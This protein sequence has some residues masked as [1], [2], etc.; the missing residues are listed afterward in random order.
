MRLFNYFIVV[1]LLYIGIGLNQ[2]S[3][4]TDIIQDEFI[5]RVHPVGQGNCVTV[6]F[7]DKENGSPEY[8]IVDLGTSSI[9]NESLIGDVLEKEAKAAPGGG[10]SKKKKSENK[11]KKSMESESD[12]LDIIKGHK[13][14]KLP[15]KEF[16]EECLEGI[17]K[18]LSLNQPRR[19]YIK[20]VVLTHGDVDH[21]NE[22]VN[23]VRKHK[24]QI[25]NLILGGCGAQINF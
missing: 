8:M 11:T 23:F 4:G 5:V 10:K 9:K 19:K 20:V 1:L 13:H 6:K 18:L 15:V 3:I 24:Y 12:L 22:L 2:K 25:G 14:S 16:K 21:T 17:D 7:Y